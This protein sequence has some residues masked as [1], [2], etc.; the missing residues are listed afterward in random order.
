M[1]GALV[2]PVAVDDFE[3]SP[4]DKP[5]VCEIDEFVL[6]LHSGFPSLLCSVV[7]TQTSVG[8]ADSTWEPMR[9]TQRVP[10]SSAERVIFPCDL[11]FRQSPPGGLKCLC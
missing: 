3:V 11:W 2:A 8:V 9:E 6:V 1:W 7:V 10:R 4:T 5:A